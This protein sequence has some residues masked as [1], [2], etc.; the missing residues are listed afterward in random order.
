MAKF[1]VQRMQNLS[2]CDT[3]GGMRMNYHRK[4]SKKTFDTF[5]EALKFF[6]ERQL[7]SKFAGL[8]GEYYTYPLEIKCS[9]P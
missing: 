7:A 4:L 1:M 3:V 2:A 5:E 6:E 9:K 8:A